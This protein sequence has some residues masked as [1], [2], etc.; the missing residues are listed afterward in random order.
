MHH[1]PPNT[2][3]VGPLY[4]K[5]VGHSQTLPAVGSFPSVAWNKAR[6]HSNWFPVAKVDTRGPAICHL[7]A[8]TGGVVGRVSWT[9]GGQAFKAYFDVGTGVRF[10]LVADDVELSAVNADAGSAAPS[11][12]GAIQPA[13]T[14][15]VRP[16]CLVLSEYA[17]AVAAGSSA[18]FNIPPF[19]RR[20]MVIRGDPD[21][22]A[23]ETTITT[24][25]Q[26]VAHYDGDPTPNGVWRELPADVTAFT[27]GNP[28][29]ASANMQPMVV[30]G[31]EI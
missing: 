4:G 8:D 14:A 2:S 15:L 5:G 22:D 20:F 13:P 21:V 29:T 3:G 23:C 28:S 11:C 1:H 26:S 25:A 31:I 12:R 7:E 19:A 18:T 27:V 9:S 17:E 10:A 16:S 30:W 24:H 6:A